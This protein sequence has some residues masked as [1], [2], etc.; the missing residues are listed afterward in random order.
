MMNAKEII[1][2]LDSKIDVLRAV[3]LILGEGATVYTS[4]R[5]ELK[6]EENMGHF[7]GIVDGSYLSGTS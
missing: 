4:E 5:E 7:K 6:Y 1:K 3:S 2:M